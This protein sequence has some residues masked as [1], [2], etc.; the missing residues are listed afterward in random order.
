MRKM[1]VPLVCMAKRSYSLCANSVWPEASHSQPVS[2]LACSKDIS[3]I[4]GVVL[5]LSAQ[6]HDVR[7][8][9]G[10]A[11]LVHLA[12]ERAVTGTAV[13]EQRAGAFLVNAPPD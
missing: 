5:E 7:A 6:F 2:D 3:R 1:R 11:S 10:D 13:R 12:D 4:R 8:K 9:F